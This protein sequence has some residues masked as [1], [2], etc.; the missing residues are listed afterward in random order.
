M[1]QYEVQEGSETAIKP[2]IVWYVL[3][4]LILFV[5]MSVGFYIYING[6]F[7]IFRDNGVKHRMPVPGSSEIDFTEEGIYVVYLEWKDSSGV[8]RR[9]KET[10]EIQY[11]LKSASG[12]EVELRE[13]RRGDFNDFNMS[14]GQAIIQFTIDKPGKYMF[15]AEFT[16]GMESG[17]SLSISKG[18][19]MMQVFRGAFQA[20]VVGLVSLALSVVICLVTY[21]K[22]SKA[23]KAQLKEDYRDCYGR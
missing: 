23:R 16:A 9:V 14:R 18:K 4:V 1:E 2:G 22:R 7:S 15:S 8:Y 21:L 20:M 19:D 13:Q 11:N 12:A 5:G 3:G 10:P 17:I 6:F